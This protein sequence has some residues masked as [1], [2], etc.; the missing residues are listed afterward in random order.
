[1]KGDGNVIIISYIRIYRI[2]EALNKAIKSFTAPFYLAEVC[3]DKQDY[4][5]AKALLLKAN[6]RSRGTYRHIL[7]RLGQIHWQLKE[8]SSAAAVFE[9]VVRLDESYE[10]VQH[11]LKAARQKLSQAH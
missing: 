11:L 4:P 1:M 5:Q 10:D 3:I 9:S 2:R 8:Y 7:Y 6:K